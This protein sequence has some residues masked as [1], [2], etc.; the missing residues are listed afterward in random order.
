MLKWLYPYTIIQKWKNKHT[1]KCL[2]RKLVWIVVLLYSFK[3][4]LSTC[5][6][7]NHSPRTTNL[8][9][10][11]KKIGSNVAPL[12]TFWFPS[13]IHLWR[14]LCRS[15]FY[16]SWRWYYLKA[17]SQKSVYGTAEGK[18]YFLGIW[19]ILFDLR[20]GIISGENGI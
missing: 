20:V 10:K 8:K 19:V 15:P 5:I 13:S 14:F 7:Q 1:I 12:S 18:E 6:N 11:G 9:N 2:Q 17:D 3:I 4:L 16:C